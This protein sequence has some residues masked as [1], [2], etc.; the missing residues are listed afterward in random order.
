MEKRIDA[1]GSSMA[2][3]HEAMATI[4]VTKEISA[5]A[6]ILEPAGVTS[7]EIAFYLDAM[8]EFCKA[9][10]NFSSVT[11]DNKCYDLLCGYR[12]KGLAEN[13]LYQLAMLCECYPLGYEYY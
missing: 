9:S 12:D 8:R 1:Y 3:L 7:S 5:K 10:R 6:S 4:L 13:L 11:R 2:D